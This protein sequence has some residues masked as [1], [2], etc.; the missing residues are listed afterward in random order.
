MSSVF[1]WLVRRE[2]ALRR[3]AG[4]E[5]RLHRSI[6]V[7]IEPFCAWN[8]TSAAQSQFGGVYNLEFSPD[9]Y[10]VC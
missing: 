4:E 3:L 6:Y 5:E 9:G 8:K 10:V 1:S 2:R 7:N